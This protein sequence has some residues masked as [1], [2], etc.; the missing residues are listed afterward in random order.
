MRWHRRSD[1]LDDAIDVLEDGH[2]EEAEL[3]AE[4]AVVDEL[5]SM[6]QSMASRSGGKPQPTGIQNVRLRR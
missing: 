4:Q 2:Y 5:Q 1:D 3:L 6:A